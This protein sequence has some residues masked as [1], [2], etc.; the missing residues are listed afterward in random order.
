MNNPHYNRFINEIKSNIE[1]ERKNLKF[2][3]RSYKVFCY[4]F[5]LNPSH[6][7]SLYIFKRYINGDYDIIF[8]INEILKGDSKDE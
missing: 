8:K 7:I 4:D 1:N 2:N 5:K 3:F 6:Y